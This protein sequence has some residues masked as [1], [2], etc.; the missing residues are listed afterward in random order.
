[1][2]RSSTTPAGWQKHKDTHTH[3]QSNKSIQTMFV[4]SSPVTS[5]MLVY[6]FCIL[7]WVCRHTWFEVII[8]YNI[9]ETRRKVSHYVSVL[10]SCVCVC[11]PHAQCSQS[12]ILLHLT[13]CVDSVSLP[14]YQF[15]KWQ[16]GK[17]GME[18]LLSN[19]DGVQHTDHKTN[20]FGPNIILS[21]SVSAHFVS[22][23]HLMT[24]SSL[25]KGQ[26]SSRVCTVIAYTDM[27]YGKCCQHHPSRCP[28]LSITQPTMS[29]SPSLQPLKHT[30]TT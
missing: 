7:L 8:M 3:I 10:W 17:Q 30:P 28:L 18:M 26:R 9:M 5:S 11:A 13:L 4:Q 6:Y 16:I 22:W 23:W 25:W 24:Q 2:R 12:Y 15:P 19:F 21:W 14:Q 27:K 20:S 1:M 29:A